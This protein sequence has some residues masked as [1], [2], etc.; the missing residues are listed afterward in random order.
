M[1]YVSHCW[2]MILCDGNTLL[3]D[4][5]LVFMICDIGEE[6]VEQAIARQSAFVDLKAVYIAGI[7]V[8][9]SHL[10]RLFFL[11]STLFPLKAK[12]SG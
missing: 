7:M 2:H 9:I 10:C 11:R 12:E 1:L 5:L 4:W 6:A 8:T 3:R